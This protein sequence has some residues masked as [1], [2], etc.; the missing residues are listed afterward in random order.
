MFLGQFSFTVAKQWKN[1]K[2]GEKWNKIAEEKNMLKT[3][4][5]CKIVFLLFAVFVW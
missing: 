3:I 1:N 4:F 5:K 2:V